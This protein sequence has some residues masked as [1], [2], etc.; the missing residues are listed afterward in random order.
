MTLTDI[1][2]GSQVVAIKTQPVQVSGEAGKG[3]RRLFGGAGLGAAIGAIAGG[4]EGAAI[5]AASG[6]AVGGIATAA[7]DQAPADMPAQSVQSFSVAV[8]FAVQ[9]MTSVAVR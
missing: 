7:S 1:Q 9:V 6:L 3:R 4:G 2:V 8:P 5:G